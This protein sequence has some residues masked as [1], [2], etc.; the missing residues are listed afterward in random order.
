MRP[1]PD[2]HPQSAPTSHHQLPTVS[3]GRGQRRED[4]QDS[5]EQGEDVRR[6]GS[7]GPGRDMRRGREGRLFGSPGALHIAVW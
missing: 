6:H 1:S 7:A 5:G 4:V 2:C 3:D